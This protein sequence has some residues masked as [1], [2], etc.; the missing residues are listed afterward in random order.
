MTSS[1]CP[2]APPPAPPACWGSEPPCSIERRSNW[3]A[4]SGFK[5]T[6]LICQ[7]Q[8]A[9]CPLAQQSCCTLERLAATQ[10]RLLIVD[11]RLT[12]VLNVL[13]KDTSCSRQGCRQRQAAPRARPPARLLLRWPP[14]PHRYNFLPATRRDAHHLH[15]INVGM[16]YWALTDHYRFLGTTSGD[17]MLQH[18][19]CLSSMPADMAIGGYWR[20]HSHHD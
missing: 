13:S 2:R 18:A 14:A 11:L 7:K 10:V 8:C 20:G 4:A 3:F 6:H 9:E 12:A 1:C 5:Y 16:Y 17:V 15:G 19:V